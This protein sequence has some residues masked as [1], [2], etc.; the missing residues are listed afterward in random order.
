MTIRILIGVLLGTALAASAH[1]QSF[2]GTY[3]GTRTLTKIKSTGQGT[4]N[5]PP[6]GQKS[7]I[8]LIVEGP[9][10][11]G[12]SPENNTRS[13]GQLASDGSFTITY[14]AG[15][16]GGGPGSGTIPVTWSGRI[17]GSRIRAS[18]IVRS[19]A[20]DCIGTISARK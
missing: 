3:T 5:C 11:T 16:W 15:F 19:P 12:V 14:G 13:T 7:P 2:D 4:L 9:T 1:A 6:V 8:V 10:I 18:F 17:R 20:G